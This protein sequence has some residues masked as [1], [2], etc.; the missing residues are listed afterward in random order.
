MPIINWNTIQ[1]DLGYGGI[2][3]VTLEDGVLKYRAFVTNNALLKFKHGEKKGFSLVSLILRDNVVRI[4]Y[5][6][7]ELGALLKLL[8]VTRDDIIPE[9]YF[10]K[11]VL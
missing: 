5:V 8:G 4:I 3:S 6:P 7:D 10:E 11:V 1:P 2:L 9:K